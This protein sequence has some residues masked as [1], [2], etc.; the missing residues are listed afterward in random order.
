MSRVILALM[1]SAGGC[2]TTEFTETDRWQTKIVDVGSRFRIVLPAT[3]EWASPTLK[4]KSVHFLR[5]AQET[6]VGALFEFS[7]DREGE[8]QILIRAKPDWGPDRDFSMRVWVLKSEAEAESG[9][10]FDD[11]WRDRWGRSGLERDD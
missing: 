8:T 11:D 9:S 4:G 6:T 10:A 7:A 5:Q 1:V 2:A 3:D